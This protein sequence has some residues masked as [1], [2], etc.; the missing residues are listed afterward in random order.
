MKTFKENNYDKLYT[1]LPIKLKEC[2]IKK[3]NFTNEND[4]AGLF[5]EFLCTV[6]SHLVQIPIMCNECEGLYC[7]DCFQDFI[8]KF[9]NCMKCQVELK[10]SK[11]Q[12]TTI[13]ILKSLMVSCPFKCQSEFKNENLSEHLNNCSL[14]PRQYK[15]HGCNNLLKI[16]KDEHDRI[17]NHIDICKEIYITC[18][19]C[20]SEIKRNLMSKHE[21]TCDS[22]IIKCEECLVEFKFDLIN[23]HSKIECV[24]YIKTKYE[25]EIKKLLNEII[26]KDKEISELRGKLNVIETGRSLNKQPEN[27]QNNTNMGNRTNSHNN[28]ND[29]Q[30]KTNLQERSDHSIPK[31]A[32][33]VSDIKHLTNKWKAD[34][35]INLHKGTINC[36]LKM[37]WN[38]DDHTILSGT[39]DHKIIIWNYI[40][41]KQINILSGHTNSVKCL[42]Q[43]NWDT[44]QT[45][46]ISGSDDNSIIVWNVKLGSKIKSIQAHADGVI[47]LAQI[48]WKKNQ[49]TIV[50]GGSDRY[51]KLWSINEAKCIGS[52]L[53]DN[54]PIISFVFL[55]WIDYD[56]DLI[57][58]AGLSKDILV[59][60]IPEG[61]C[62]ASLKG[63]SKSINCLLL[64]KW[65]LN[66]FTL[67]S[68]S[69]DLI[70][71][72]WNLETTICF[73]NL[74][75][76]KNKIN[77][78][79][80]IK[81][82]ID[83]KTILSC[84]SDK[85]IRIWNVYE[86]N[87]IGLMDESKSE[88]NC[89]TIVIN[90]KDKN[91]K[92]SDDLIVLSGCSDSS[93]IIWKK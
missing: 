61:K 73:R 19:Y 67:V 89:F 55:P 4:E 53:S 78:I 91:S 93:I 51:I 70:I 68:A 40:D 44:D 42:T 31:T 65:V 86:S 90:S 32:S 84:S 23:S 37:K 83:D 18:K 29:I 75:G 22:K 12:K 15:C 71:K 39:D 6:C 79:E 59:H 7:Q 64:M 52:F 10:T 11:I 80:Q 41:A 49:T 43:M 72:L 62:V 47:T 82:K 85:T 88:I 63:H 48:Q 58:S 26:S 34:R 13:N 81:W 74:K 5:N 1:I 87:C 21:K 30:I 46:V 36:L 56:G 17:L 33:N 3:E 76:H 66:D 50:S 24:S 2:K 28:G 20:K 45:T 57:V 69:D 92:D 25:T 8:K 60:E 9:S 54:G 35:S 38:F 16:K 27:L 14:I 77:H